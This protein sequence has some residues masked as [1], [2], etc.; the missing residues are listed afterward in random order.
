MTTTT[1]PRP[2]CLKCRHVLRSAK[3]IARGYGPTCAKYIKENAAAA[4]TDFKPVQ[5]EKALELIEL[6]AIA[7]TV[8]A[9]LFEV[10]SSKGD[11]R[12][13][14]NA[15]TRACTCRAGER[16]VRCYHLAA[17]QILTAA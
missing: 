6:G 17:A 15:A 3:S 1:D 7:A 2:R 8:H 10:V 11:D 13:F 4:A 16:G 9:L 5:V 14:V 12:Y